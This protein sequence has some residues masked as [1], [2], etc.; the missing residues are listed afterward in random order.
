[1]GARHIDIAS[2]GFTHDAKAAISDLRRG[3]SI[4]L[5]N[6]R[7]VRV[8]FRSPNGEIGRRDLATHW[9]H[10]YPAKMLHLIPAT[11]LDSIDLP[12]SATILDPFCGSGTVLL[13]ASLRGYHSIGIDIN[14]LAQLISRTKVTPICPEKLQESFDQVFVSA[15]RSRLKPRVQPILDFWLSK[16]ARAALYRLAK[17]ID[18]IGD[19]KC[20]EF[21][22]VTLTSIV[23]KVS[24]ADPAVPPLV[25]MQSGRAAIAGDRYAIALNRTRNLTTSFV[26]DTFREAATANIRRMS[27][28]YA[29]SSDLGQAIVTQPGTHASESGLP[30][31]SVDAII[32]SP[33]YC[34]AQKYVRSTKLEMIIAGTRSEDLPRLDRITLGTEAVSSVGINMEELNTGDSCTDETIGQIFARNPIRARMASNYAKYLYKFISE[35]N[36]LVK[37]GGHVVVALGRSTIAGIAFQPDLIATKAGSE[38]GLEHIATLVDR[39][40]S[41]GLFTR[42]HNTANTIDQE[43]VIWLQKPA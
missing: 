29:V 1:M 8:A 11:F 7:V 4:H 30:S 21:F 10:W 26:Y 39:I 40:P 20:R 33:P 22:V 19:D 36:R 23:R 35:C 37:P 2:S 27:E 18:R 6:G 28:L 38:L 34:G 41:R 31:E 25:R 15:K 24:L 14:P 17:K 32:T 5:Q 3:G 42:R 13:E 43:H 9:I 16:P 12:K